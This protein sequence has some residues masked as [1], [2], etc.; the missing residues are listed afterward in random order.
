MISRQIANSTKLL[1]ALLV[2]F[3][4]V[5]L[6][7][8]SLTFSTAAARTEDG[9]PTPP[10]PAP[11]VYRVAVTDSATARR[12]T[13]SSFDLLEVGGSGYLLVLGDAATGDQLRAAGFAAT[14][15]AVRTASFARAFREGWPTEY[16]TV[17]QHYQHLDAVT[18]AHPELARLIVYGQS[19][20]KANGQP[21]GFDLKALCL[22]RQQPGDCALTPNASKPRFLLMAN[23]HAREISTGEM[24]WRWIDYLVDGY[25]ADPDVTWLLDDHELWVIPIVNPD[26]H[27]IVETSNLGQRKNANANFC[28][29]GTSGM[30]ET[31]GV[32]LNRNAS[33]QWNVSGGSANACDDDFVGP[34]PASEPEEVALESLL[35]NLF[36]VQRGPQITDTAPL[37]TTG[38]M[39]T[40]HSY[41]DLVLLPWGWQECPVLEECPPE[42]R[43]P[44]DAG[45]RAFAFRLSYYN[46][47][48]TGQACELLY[49]AS[50]TTDDW[51]YGRLGVP[52]FTFEIG[53]D[54][55]YPPP[56]ECTGFWPP[57]HCQDDLFWP[58]NRGAF[59]YAARVARQPYATAPGPTVLTVTVGV[60][61]AVMGQ[62]VTLTAVVDDAA[63]GDN[64]FGQPTAHTVTAAEYYV[65][66][67]P[68]AGGA[69]HP[70][71][72]T[73]DG[74]TT[75]VTGAVQTAGLLPG[76]HLLFV[77]GR[78]EAGFWGP[79]SAQW[80]S[81]QGWV[82][83]LPLVLAE[84][85]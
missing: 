12:L 64:G 34:G 76:R 70:M 67:P 83:Y 40:L 27:Q 19:W 29:Q 32:D 11:V 63:Y 82:Q 61:T 17:A 47:Y 68:W 8:T 15:D 5:C 45:L 3:G 56:P 22:T 66:T 37:T 74:P 84:P 52:G 80:L 1:L 20:R 71:Q 23:L 30:T 58:L 50:G 38:A 18:A 62:A 53:P 77:R 79:V 75:V 41:S 14:M 24:A 59:L 2:G 65:D 73:F 78:N 26:G 85:Q 9:R 6:F 33:F 36:P 55:E 13:A 21:N 60:S 7:I 25:G 35:R 31:V 28:P 49:G 43:A 16:R 69:P 51:I 10:P 39:L 72:G 48:K 42:K 57:Y 81:I 44:N 46:G 4:G 54:V